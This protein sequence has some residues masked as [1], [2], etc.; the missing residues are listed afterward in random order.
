MAY[1]IAVLRLGKRKLTGPRR[2]RPNRSRLVNN[3]HRCSDPC[4]GRGR[5]GGREV[6]DEMPPRLGYTI[7]YVPDIRAA[8]AFYERAF[9]FS[10]L[11]VDASPGWA[12]LDAGGHTLGFSSHELMNR[13]LPAGF[14]P[15]EPAGPPPG[16]ELDVVVDDLAELHA[17]L[18]RALDAGA[19]L[20]E[21]P[22][23]ADD[24]ATIAFLRDPVGVIVE[25]QTPYQGP[26]D[27]GRGG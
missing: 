9:G 25:V 17:T 14:T 11:E 22:V 5:R 15:I 3:M 18:A 21:P 2:T 6:R 16:F 8:A 27:P 10:I 23:V 24:G 7:V 4:Q 13:F 26:P 12:M 20:L 19:V 1:D